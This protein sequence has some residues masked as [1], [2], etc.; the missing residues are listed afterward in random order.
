M[1][2]LVGTRDHRWGAT[3]VLDQCFWPEGRSIPLVLALI[4]IAGLDSTAMSGH[5]MRVV[6][7]IDGLCFKISDGECPVP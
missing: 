5:R 4:A 6:T 2:R 1:L 3:V 7:I